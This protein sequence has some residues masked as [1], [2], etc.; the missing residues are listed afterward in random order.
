MKKH[1]FTMIEMIVVIVIMSVLSLG[2]MVSIKHLYQRVAKSKALSELSFD[3]QLVV[4]QVSALLYDRVPKMVWGYEGNITNKTQ[5]YEITSNGYKIVEWYG[6]A[7]E[8][9]KRGDYS[10]FID[11]DDSNKSNNELRTY[12]INKTA[13]KEVL[14]N[15]FG[16]LNHTIKNSLGL[17]FA[18]SFDAGDSNISDINETGLN[19]IVLGKKPSEIYEKY[20]L[21]DS[22]Y[23]VGRGA[24]I[25]CSDTNETNTLYLIY[26]Y[27]PWK[28]KNMCDGN[29]TTLAK[30]VKGF[31]IGLINDSIFF[32][33]TLSRHIKGVEQNI[34][35]SK[36]K[37]V[38]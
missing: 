19:K 22:A 25:N 24:D 16:G 21:V 20:Y 13:I 15:K 29:I 26:N 36:Q 28:N 6:T 35:I 7:S 32:N 30:E 8:S 10:G 23:A 9:Y 27:R 2:T 34:T 14:N 1:G 4:D 37:V 38:F 18:G 5:I 12:D 11:M 31:E 33:L 17:V 3:S